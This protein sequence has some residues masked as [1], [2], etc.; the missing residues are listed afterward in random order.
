LLPLAQAAFGRQQAQP[1][2]NSDPVPFFGN[3]D[4][5]NLLTI[6]HCIFL[7]WL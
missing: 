6:A 1:L 4:P 3:C 7:T 2:V 5:L